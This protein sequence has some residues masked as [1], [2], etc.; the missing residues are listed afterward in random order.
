MVSNLI[1][2]TRQ[3]LRV[4]AWYRRGRKKHVIREQLKLCHR[5]KPTLHA[6]HGTD[7]AHD[8]QHML[9]AIHGD[10]LEQANLRFL[11]LLATR[12]EAG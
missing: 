4:L 1:Q 3:R 9:Q 5:R 6:V 10:S 8:S 12:S 2:R 7:N 11:E